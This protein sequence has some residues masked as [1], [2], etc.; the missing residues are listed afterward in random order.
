[1]LSCGQLFLAGHMPFVTFKFDNAFCRDC[2]WLA[3]AE[4]Q[5]FIACSGHLCS[6]KNG[7]VFMSNL[8]AFKNMVE[9]SGTDAY[10]FRTHVLHIHDV[11]SKRQIEQRSLIKEP[12][13]HLFIFR[14]TVILV[15]VVVDP[16]SLTGALS[17]KRE[18]TLN[19]HTH[20]ILSQQ[21]ASKHVFGIHGY[22]ENIQK[23]TWTVTRGTRAK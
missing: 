23:S 2:Y 11:Q 16:K 6:K 19:V 20:T 4:I 1:M 15:S 9:S 17:M 8:K 21:S 5:Q 13:F 22:G 10:T 3:I 18:Y 12:E 7:N 14:K